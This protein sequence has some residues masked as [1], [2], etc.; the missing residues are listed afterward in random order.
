MALVVTVVDMEV[1]VL[2]KPLKFILVVLQIL[3]HVIIS[4]L[5]LTATLHIQSMVLHICSFHVCVQEWLLPGLT[6]SFPLLRSFI[7]KHAFELGLS[8]I[9]VSGIQEAFLL[10]YFY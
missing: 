5:N 1:A 8:A 10:Y 7:Q 4:A 9:S 6:H 2:G 3:F